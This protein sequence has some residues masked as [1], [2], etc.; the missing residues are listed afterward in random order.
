MTGL[1][2]HQEQLCAVVDYVHGQDL[3]GSLNCL[4]EC[5]EVGRRLLVDADDNIAFSEA[6]PRRQPC[7]SSIVLASFWS[8]AIGEQHQH[9]DDEGLRAIQHERALTRDPTPNHEGTPP[10][11]PMTAMHLAIR[12]ENRK[13]FGARVRPGWGPVGEKI[14]RQF[15]SGLSP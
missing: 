4:V 8:L 7:S 9:V 1:L 10:V 6:A 5:F 12:A 11:P 14:L 13:W 15:F 2:Q 3:G